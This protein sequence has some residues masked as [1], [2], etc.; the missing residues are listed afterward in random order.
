MRFNVAQLI[1]LTFDGTL[2]ESFFICM[3][4]SLYNSDNTVISFTS[5]F[6]LYKNP[7][8]WN[9]WNIHELLSHC[10]QPQAPGETQNQKALLSALIKPET[11]SY[12]AN[13]PI[14]VTHTLRGFITHS[15]EIIGSSRCWIFHVSKHVSKRMGQSGNRND[16]QTRAEDEKR[17]YSCKLISEQIL[18]H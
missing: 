8:V 2:W 15:L 13:I 10:L 1:F 17:V 4:V 12:T 16:T 18:L 5:C 9:E 11:C 6:V 3:C 7:A 14:N